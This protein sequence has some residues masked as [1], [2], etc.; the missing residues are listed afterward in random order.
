MALASLPV[1]VEETVLEPP[2]FVRD[3]FEKSVRENEP[4]SFLLQLEATDPDT[5][6]DQLTYGMTSP[7]PDITV[8][9]NGSVFSLS[10]LDADGARNPL[11]FEV[12]VTDGHS[13]DTAQLVITVEDVNEFD[14][15]LNISS[16]TPPFKVPENASIGEVVTALG[17]TDRDVTNQGF[18]FWL[19]DGG[20]G[21]FRLND[22]TGLLEVSGHLDRRLTQTYQ[23]TVA[24]SD[25]GQPPR[26]SWDQ[27]QV[28]VES[29]NSRPEFVGDL[30]PL[31]A[32][33]NVSESLPLGALLI[34]LAASDPDLGSSGQLTFS[35]VSGNEDGVFDLDPHSGNL[36]LAKSLNYELTTEYTLLL[37]VTDHS[38]PPASSPVATLHVHVINEVEAPLWPLPLPTVYLS[39]SATCDVSPRLQAFSREVTS[40]T[41]QADE[42]VEYVVRNQTNYFSVNKTTGLLTTSQMVPE[43]LYHVP[44]AAC[45]A[46][47]NV[48][49]EAVLSVVVRSDNI[50]AFCPVFYQTQVNESSAPG[51]LVLDL[52]T[53]KND[54]SV[55]YNITAGNG[56]GCFRINASTGEIFLARQL[57]RE[58][59]ANY[60]LLISAS[61][62]DTGQTADAQV[63]VL[64]GDTAD[65]APVFLSPLYR[66]EILEDAPL[67]SPV[68]LA[69]TSIPLEVKATDQDENSQI[70]YSIV[71]GSDT[72]AG[73][74]SVDATSGAI[75]LTAS[76]DRETMDP[77]LGSV[78][79]MTILASEG[80]MDANTT[81]D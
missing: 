18:T 54:A 51:P 68:L 6:L 58:R 63:I 34:T 66:G 65:T 27:L 57:D 61:E 64:V 22:T 40:L 23:L 25:H 62:V 10:G 46:G 41:S 81:V 15:Q 32:S 9:Q 47:T 16:S 74:F 3:K 60:T 73:K 43:G 24:V 20:Q 56:E 39:Q 80:Y 53:N 11:T 31:T 35:V 78:Y 29:S 8:S 50:L 70:R 42:T 49:S 26:H 2:K 7:D 21:K 45:S 76:L 59:T 14:P 12:T 36:T 1:D 75:T 55:S 17:A 67:H 5:P 79:T 4:P 30:R 37:K 69:F 28:E 44:L 52:N 13:T 19:S 77:S 48:C 38:L 71:P 72:S 33:I